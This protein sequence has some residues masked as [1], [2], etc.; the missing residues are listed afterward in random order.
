M[1][2]IDKM[3]ANM[4]KYELKELFR[5]FDNDMIEEA[6]EQTGLGAKG[7]PELTEGECLTILNY[8]RKAQTMQ[9]EDVKDLWPKVDAIKEKYQNTKTGLMEDFIEMADR[10]I[11]ELLSNVAIR[12]GV[13]ASIPV[14]WEYSE[15]HSGSRPTTFDYAYAWMWEKIEEYKP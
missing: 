2:E 5:E 10:Y 4:L 13:L 7:L 12:N 8:V 3:V 11:T 14:N 6:F 15:L 9:G 1:S